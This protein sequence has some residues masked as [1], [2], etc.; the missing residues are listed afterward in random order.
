MS[1]FSLLALLGY[2]EILICG[3][4]LCVIAAKRL[5]T[6]YWA[7]AAFLAVRIAS[8]LSLNLIHILARGA[9]HREAFY[10]SYFY[11]YWTAFGI[12]AVLGLLIIYST[13]RLTLTPLRGLQKLGKTV[14]GITFA[15]GLLALGSVITRSMSGTE[16]LMVTISQLQRTQSLL[17]LCVA[18]LVLVALRPMGYS[19]RSA[20]FGIGL[21]L[22]LMSIN[23]LVQAVLHALHPSVIQSSLL[24]LTNGLVMCLSLLI[25]TAYLAMPE[26]KR[27]DIASPLLRWN[28]R[29]I[30]AA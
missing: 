15:I 17:T 8:D 27:G 19:F 28:E 16:A 21:G 9:T 25:W 3:A 7:L 12:E 10:S 14:F 24:N 26:P 22:S 23:D 30:G 11:V 18:L 13:F 2:A 1:S 5:W 6:P 4:G 29:L 20:V